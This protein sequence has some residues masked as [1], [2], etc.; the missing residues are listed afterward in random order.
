MVNAVFHWYSESPE[1]P[2]F[3]PEYPD[4]PEISG[5]ARTVRTF[6]HRIY[7]ASSLSV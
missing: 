4:F 6:M 7:F 2:D 1:S 5:L 3:F